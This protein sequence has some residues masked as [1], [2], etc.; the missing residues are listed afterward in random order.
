MSLPNHYPLNFPYEDT[1]YLEALVRDYL[2]LMGESS[3][4][5]IDTSSHSLIMEYRDDRPNER[6]LDRD[7]VDA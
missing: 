4:E 3:D 5:S 7:R 2:E 1:N 6:T